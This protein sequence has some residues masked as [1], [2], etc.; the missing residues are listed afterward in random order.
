MRLTPSPTVI[1]VDEDDESKLGGIEP[2]ARGEGFTQSE[3]QKVAGE[4]AAAKYEKAAF[5]QH[6]A[7]QA[8]LEK[9]L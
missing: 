8:Q 4:L 6:Y 3:A 7:T 9:G 2:L 5:F 1:S